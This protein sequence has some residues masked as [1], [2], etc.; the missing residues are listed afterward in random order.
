MLASF[1]LSDEFKSHLGLVDGRIAAS[2]IMLAVLEPD[3]RQWVDSIT[4]AEADRA[5]RPLDRLTVVRHL[6]EDDR[7]DTALHAVGIHRRDI[8]SL[9]AALVQLDDTVRIVGA[10]AL[11]DAAHYRGQLADDQP[12]ADPATHYVLRGEAQG[13]TPSATFDAD[14]YAAIHADVAATGFNRLFHYE[15]WGRQEGRAYRD[16][17]TYQAMPPLSADSG[18]PTVLLLVHEASYTGAPLLAWN[19]VRALADRCDIVVVLRRGGP[20]ET[21]LRE[22]ASVVLEAPPPEAI[23][24]GHE[25]DRYAERLA[26]IY[27]PLYTIANSIESWPVATALRRHAVPVVALVHEFLPGVAP[28][29]RSDFYAACAALVFSARIVERSSFRAF[30]EI[31]L[32]NRAILPQGPCAIPPFD[33]SRRPVPFVAP[34]AAGDDAAPT[35][36]ALLADGQRGDGPFTVIGLGAV[37]MRKGID[38]FIAAAT[39]LRAKHPALAFRFIWI[40]SWEQALGTEYAA[41]LA[42]QY[43]RSGLADRLHFFPTIDD[44]EPVYARADALLLSSRLDPLPNVTIDAAFRGIPV[45][46]FDGASGTAELLAADPATA[47]LVVPHLDSGAA[48]DRL[49]A[50]AADAGLREACGAAMRR[51]AERSFDMAAYARSIDALGQAAARKFEQMGRDRQLI[52]DAQAFDASIYLGAEHDD[53]AAETMSAATYLNRTS[54]INFASPPVFGVILRRPRPGFHPFIYGNEAPDFPRDGSRDPLAHYVERGMPEGRWTHRIIRPD[55][56]APED[57][58]AP[59]GAVALHGHFHYADNIADFLAALAANRL[60]ADLFLTTDSLETAGILRTATRDYAKG[61]V[62]VE[63]GPNVGR[64]IYAFLRVLRTHIAGRYDVVGHLHGKRSVHMVPSDPGFGDRWRHFLWEHLLGPTHRAADA[65]VD[66]MRRDA[67]L[68]LVFPENGFLI[69]WEKNGESAAA[70]ARRIGLNAALPAHIEFPAGTMFWARAAILDKLVRAGFEDA[71][72]PVEPLP[73]DGTVLHALERVLPLL[74]VDAGYGY[75]T[76]Y[77][78]DIRR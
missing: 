4:D 33:R 2:E 32:Q 62:V 26:A 34:F 8:D 60:R 24:N 72:M 58:P 43:E 74:C 66:A 22:V 51:L 19:L 29:I 65:I 57:D 69:G 48:A 23:L 12:V 40:G 30:R 59:D 14:T 54:H 68:G 64:D 77:I 36:D 28:G 53:A 50:L 37:E 25:M 47:A 76:T 17:L 49:A 10:S 44:L 1:M 15:M 71:D 55:L 42:E 56:A 11:F 16:W 18:R 7:I 45:V 38:L 35:L 39:A 67:R 41:L 31:G 75:A 52:E 9:K 13:L 3:L 61:G 5:G 70:L 27:R 21:A 6:L 20:L 63:V 78:P 46:C 73:I